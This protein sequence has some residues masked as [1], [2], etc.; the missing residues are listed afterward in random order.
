[1]ATSERPNSGPRVLHTVA[2]PP[3]NPNSTIQHTPYALNN[4]T[5]T[6]IPQRSYAFNSTS[7]TISHRTSASYTSTS[8]TQYTLNTKPVMP[9]SP[10]SAV[11]V[12][13]SPVSTYA[14]HPAATVPSPTASS[15]APRPTASIPNPNTNAPLPPTPNTPSGISGPQTNNHAPLPPTK[16]S[17]SQVTPSS[18]T[19]QIPANNSPTS[20]SNSNSNT[21]P[22]YTYKFHDAGN[23][24]IT[25]ETDPAL[26]TFTTTTP[27]GFMDMPKKS[28]VT[29]TSPG[30]N[31]A[32][33]AVQGE[34]DWKAKK[35]TVGNVSKSMAD[36]K[37]K[38]GGT[39]SL[40]TEWTW[41]SGV[42]TITHNSRTW[43]AT[44]GGRELAI[45]T[46]LNVKAFS[47]NELATLRFLVNMPFE[48]RVFLILALM[49]HDFQLPPVAEPQSFKERAG[50]A[51]VNVATTVATNVATNAITS[52]CVVQ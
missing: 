24:Q 34:F 45:Y 50:E 4:P 38:I 25:C 17:Q 21:V 8:G 40:D 22:I 49:F 42:Y 27:R 23:N 47:K 35:I 29:C 52:C 36:A 28:V 5:T 14:S 44:R 11:G 32:R 39:F 46:S 13:H 43:T 12:Q 37:K 31:G 48:E 41:T 10:S 33:N 3:S 6:V 2:T 9:S 16:G 1:M 30:G 26:P 15:Y 51:G 18:L 7:P 20:N 19:V